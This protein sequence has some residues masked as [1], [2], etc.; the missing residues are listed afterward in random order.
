MTEATSPSPKLPP[1]RADLRVVETAVDAG[2]T[3]YDPLRH[4]FFRLDATATILVRIWP[5]CRSAQGIVAACD[6]AFGTIVS[7]QQVEAFA[8]WLATSELTDAD[9]EKVWRQR[10]D[11]VARQRHGWLMW[12]VH[13]YLFV[14]IPILAPQRAL[15]ALMPWLVPFFSR[16]FLA[17]IAACGGLALYLAGREWERLL[18]SLPELLSLQTGLLFV[19]ALAI[20][21]SLHELGHAAM[22]TRFGCRVPSMGLCFMVMVPM[23]YTDVSDAWKLSSRR[24]RLLIDAAGILVEVCIACIALLAWVLLAE[25]PVKS[26]AAMLA[27]T[28]VLLSLGLNLNP[29]MRFDGYYILSDAI[30]VENLQGRS[31]A[32]GRWK[33]RDWLFGL[34]VAAP[35]RFS[36]RK[37]AV[38]IAYAWV[39]WLYRLVLFTGI[40]LLVYQMSFKLLGIALF[41]VEIVFFIALPLWR[42]A[43]EWWA[44]RSAILKTKRTLMSAALASCV[45]AAACVPWSTRI[46]IPAVL[47]D[48]ELAQLYPKRAAFVVESGAMRGATVARGALIATLVSPELE[49]EITLTALKIKQTRRRLER[50]PGDQEERGQTHVLEQAL[51]SFESRLAGLEAERQELRLVAP[52]DGTITELDPHLFPSRWLQR[53]DLVALIRGERADVVRGYVSESDVARLDI[54]VPATFTPEDIGSS[55]RDVKILSIAP[56]GTGALDIAELAS[57]HGGSVATRLQQRPGEPRQFVPVTGQ[58]LVTATPVDSAHIGGRR[59]MRGVLHAHGRA[60]SFVART[61][62]HILKV[63]VRESGF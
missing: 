9:D 37:T 42:E 16:T 40:A 50:R 31:F 53:S 48:G 20:V 41:V 23:L 45:I 56:V 24:Q 17:L 51:A 14:K 35:E 43:R 58:F 63:L 3:L 32:L 34:G 8:R 26:L 29:L 5:Q 7:L 19:V 13:N 38:L 22:A 4:R 36:R 55:R 21:K 2:C 12:A 52:I 47:E 59:S 1:L 10:L 39:V 49:Q 15:V 30:G 6:V 54:T 46:D 11:A 60:E 62:R 44:M 33:L 27:T 28:S 61:W 57:Q 18:A 25:G